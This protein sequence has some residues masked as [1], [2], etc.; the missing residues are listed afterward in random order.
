MKIDEGRRYRTGLPRHF[1][2]RNDDG[3]KVTSYGIAASLRS[4]Q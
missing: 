1:V 3:K 4:S 2:P